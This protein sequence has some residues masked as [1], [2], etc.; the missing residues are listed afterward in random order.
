MIILV[1]N[2]DGINAAGIRALATRLERDHT[3]F[4]V[5]PAR[6]QSAASHS[7]TLRR[8]LSV[9]KVG[10]RYYAVDGTPADC[11]NLAVNGILDAR[12]DLVVSGINHG[13][14]M[15][16]DVFYSGTVSAAIEG[17][18]LNIPSIAVSYEMKAARDFGPAAEFSADLV[19]Y[20]AAH[21]IPNDTVLSVNIPDTVTAD[22]PTYKI[23]K[24]GKRIYSNAIVRQTDPPG[25]GS[26]MIGPG[27]IDFED[28]LE[29]DFFA[30]TH[31]YISIT[32]L[33]LDMTNYLSIGEIKKWKI[34]TTSK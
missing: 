14:N 24:Q 28:D 21:S 19:H 10:E 30:V 9:Q 4:V 29:S 2:D 15:G 16:D 13:A 5:A 26:F 18:L 7:L 6:E 20:L 8:A 27:E 23:T 1:S 25:S 22:R 11:V 34:G 31:G 3:V 33:H 17:M 12:P 32:P